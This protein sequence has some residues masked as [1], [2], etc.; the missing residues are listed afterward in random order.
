MCVSDYQQVENIS[1]RTHKSEYGNMTWR[2][3]TRKNLRG[4]WMNA[5]SS[6]RSFITG[7]W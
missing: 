6:G 7:R 3:R 1:D 5:T 2:G 4:A